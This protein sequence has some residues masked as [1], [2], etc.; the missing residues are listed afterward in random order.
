MALLI[1]NCWRNPGKTF[2]L[3]IMAVTIRK[4]AKKQSLKPTTINL[5][6]EVACPKMHGLTVITHGG[7]H[8]QHVTY[9]GVP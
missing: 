3:Y 6:S 9:R 2:K 4:K 1:A 8:S 7:F 5:L